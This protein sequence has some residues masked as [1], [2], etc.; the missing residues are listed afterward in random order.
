MTCDL[1]LRVTVGAP[2]DHATPG[3]PPPQRVGVGTGTY[4]LGAPRQVEF[5]LW[6]TF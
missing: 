1:R 6:L 5:R 4:A 3:I 2:S